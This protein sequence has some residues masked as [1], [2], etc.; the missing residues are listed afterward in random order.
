M[1]CSKISLFVFFV[2]VTTSQINYNVPPTLGTISDNNLVGGI[3]FAANNAITNGY[4]AGYL[5]VNSSFTIGYNT[6]MNPIPKVV[7]SI[8]NFEMTQDHFYFIYV[9]SVNETKT[10]FKVNTST[11]SG[12]DYFDFNIAI[13]NF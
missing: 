1:N 3:A 6:V 7:I 2:F 11:V 12:S 8:F 5:A 4:K 10:V 9:L 13:F